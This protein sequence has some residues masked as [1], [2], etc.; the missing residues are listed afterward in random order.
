MKRLEL[1]E[2][3]DFDWLPN[4]IRTGVTNLII[5]LHKIM[6]TTDVLVEVITECKKKINFHQI[7]DLGSGSGGP[8]I[9][10]IDKINTNESSE[11]PI[12]LLLS[13]KYPHA[14]T[15]DR[16][17][18]LGLQNIRYLGD[19]VDAS[20][21]ENVPSGLKTMVASFHHMPPNVAKQIL[22][23]AEDSGEP[24]LIYELAKNTIPVIVW[25]LLLP[26][27]LMILV[28]MS[29]VFT[30]FVRPLTITQIVFTYLIPIIPI[31]Y[32]WDGQASMV[33]TYTFEDIKTLTSERR[34]EAYTWEIH[35][36]KK[37]NGKKAGYYVF[38]YSTD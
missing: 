6:G 14:T 37:K 17:N 11:E 29:L 27:S 4:Y 32:A 1:F 19:S 34:N 18:N 7:I 9:D 21:M 15:V 31:I 38:G 33:R 28:L 5:V 30:L 35:Q 3:E 8:M 13:D 25:W 22:S 2:F 12:T 10:V 23:S 26:I 36:A 16:I 24:I 20:E